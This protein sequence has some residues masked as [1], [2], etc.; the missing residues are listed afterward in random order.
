MRA[1]YGRDLADMLFELP[2]N[3]IFGQQTGDSARHV[4]DLIGRVMQER[5]S[6]QTNRSDTSVSQSAQ[7]ES[8]VPVSRI[9]KLSAGEFVGLVADDPDNLVEL[10]AFHGQIIQ[11]NKALAKAQAGFVPTPVVNAVTEKEVLA[12]FIRIR[13]EV[14]AFVE[15]EISRMMGTPSLAGLV[16]AKS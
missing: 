15:T 8:A 4:S 13:A 9:A 1:I 7:L 14:A 5:Q 16:I 2:A 10:K 3:K 12:N 11:D 6:I